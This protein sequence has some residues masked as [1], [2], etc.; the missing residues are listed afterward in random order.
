MATAPLSEEQL[1][2]IRERTNAASPGPWIVEDTPDL[3]RWVT[4]E[5]STLEANF[6]YRGNGNQSDAQFVAHAREDI[7]LLLAEIDRLTTTLDVTIQR[8]ATALAK[9]DKHK[10]GARIANAELDALREGL[11]EIGGDPT[12]VQNLYAQLSSRTSQWKA[13]QAQADAARAFADEMGDY[14]SYG[15]IAAEYARRL[16]ERL[17]QAQPNRATDRARHGAA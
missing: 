1:A 5:N 15:N 2:A 4:S 17:D 6:G 14:C 3:N 8:C 13:A 10:Q 12:Q 9:R 11:R 16:R 7:P